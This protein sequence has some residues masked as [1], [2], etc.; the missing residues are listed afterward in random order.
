MVSEW[1][2]RECGYLLH[3]ARGQVDA[4]SEDRVL[5]TRGRANHPAEDVA[6]GD[7]DRCRE[8]KVEE[9]LADVKRGQHLSSRPRDISRVKS[10][11]RRQDYFF[12]SSQ[13]FDTRV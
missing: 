9:A 8:R 4:V 13:L 6:R 10:H 7:A 3:E 2:G 11:K 5:P 1:R 12:R